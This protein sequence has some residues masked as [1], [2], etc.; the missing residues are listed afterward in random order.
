[1]EAPCIEAQD[2]WNQWFTQS[3]IEL[4]NEIFEVYFPWCRRVASSLFV[5]YHHELIEWRDFVHSASEAMLLSI[6]LYERER[7]VPFEAFAYKRLKGEVL[8]SLHLYTKDKHLSSEEKNRRLV[9]ERVHID[10]EDDDSFKMI[11]DAAIGLAFGFFLEAGI[12]DQSDG[13]SVPHQAYESHRISKKLIK[14]V[15]ELDDRKRFI[16]KAHYFQQLSFAE[17]AEVMGV[18]KARISQ[19][20]AAAIKKLKQNF[21]SD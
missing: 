6:D 14:L 19:I 7:N 11:V 16:V 10:T 17:I 9:S 4:R 12:I 8:K 1:M 13:E 15:E 21:V 2:L 3:S 5:K 18:S 20:H